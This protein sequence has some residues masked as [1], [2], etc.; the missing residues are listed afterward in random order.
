MLI[1]CSI[2]YFIMRSH[3]GCCCELSFHRPV[4]CRIANQRTPQIIYNCDMFE[5]NS[6]SSPILCSRINVIFCHLFF[7]HNILWCR[8][9]FVVHRKTTKLHYIQELGSFIEFGNK[10]FI[11]QIVSIQFVFRVDV[12][13]IKKKPSEP[14]NFP[15]IYRKIYDGRHLK[16]AIKV[17]HFW[18]YYTTSNDI[19]D[20]CIHRNEHTI[21]LLLL[22]CDAFPNK[23]DKQ[24]NSLN[25]RQ[26]SMASHT[27]L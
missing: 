20:I 5:V 24:N 4:Q 17:F 21:F 18:I 6:V 15:N 26:A 11:V 23:N 7:L 2:S 10:F 3:F 9:S 1:F 14:H 22:L 12:I 19:I 16:P 13:M 25:Y 27:W 8:E